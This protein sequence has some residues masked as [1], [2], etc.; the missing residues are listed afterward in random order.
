[1]LFICGN[2][3]GGHVLVER[4]LNQLG[5]RGMVKDGDLDILEWERSVKGKIEPQFYLILIFSNQRK[6]TVESLASKRSLRP[7]GTQE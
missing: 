1:L 5:L 4:L 2:W 7:Q 3:W 6:S